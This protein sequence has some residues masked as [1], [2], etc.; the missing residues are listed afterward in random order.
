MMKITTT[1]LAL[2]LFILN[3]GYAYAAMSQCETK[4]SRG[5]R[6]TAEAMAKAAQESDPWYGCSGGCQMDSSTA[7]SMDIT[8][9]QFEAQSKAALYKARALEANECPQFADAIMAGIDIPKDKEAVAKKYKQSMQKEYDELSAQKQWQKDHPKCKHVEW[10][11]GSTSSTED[12]SGNFEGKPG[13]CSADGRGMAWHGTDDNLTNYDPDK[14]DLIAKVRC[15]NA[16]RDVGAFNGSYADPKF[17]GDV[18]RK[19]IGEGG[20]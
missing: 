8:K 13:F 20:E 4:E 15:A 3:S 17:C 1:R 12:F 6:F 2:V 10:W 16:L 7:D 18:R 5:L 11:S 19:K 14:N 9:R